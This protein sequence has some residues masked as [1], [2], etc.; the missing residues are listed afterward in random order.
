M[1]SHEEIATMRE[2]L[3][4]HGMVLMDKV[5]KMIQ[6]GDLTKEQ[7]LFASDVMKDI[8]SIDKNLSKACYYDSIKGDT[9]ERKY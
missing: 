1:I 7:M 8:S 5:S 3:Y 4:R 6:S 9:D 2:H